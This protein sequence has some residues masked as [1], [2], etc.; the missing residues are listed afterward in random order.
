M[1]RWGMVIDLRKCFGCR[2]CTIICKET[3]QVALD[4]WRRVI[5]GGVSETT[6]RQRIFLP[7]SCMHCSDPP[8]L[9][10]CPTTATYRRTDGI[11]D[12][13]HNLCI[14]C[15]YCVVA[16]PYQARS[17]IS[18]NGYDS[19][20]ESDPSGSPT[21]RVEV[22]RDGVCTKCNFCLPRLDAGLA[23][24]LQ[25]GVDPAA[26]P[27][28]VVSCSANALHFGDLDDP[29]S[30]VSQLIRET[31]TARLQEDLNTGP[32]VYYIID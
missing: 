16:C 5:D 15:G 2:A 20:S 32:V 19:E 25:P 4:Q 9:E 26:S 6:N 11:I 13:N 10:V 22:E 30:A 14:G 3:N 28:C 18:H 23:Q 21:N 8:C 17:I 31:K 12:V 29:T 24:G 7:M 1:T 27:A